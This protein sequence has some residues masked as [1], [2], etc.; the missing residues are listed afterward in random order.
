MTP[1]VPLTLPPTISGAKGVPGPKYSIVLGALPD[2]LTL[3]SS[4]GVISGTPT[5]ASLPGLALVEVVDAFDH[6][7][8]ALVTLQALPPVANND[9]YA[10]PQDTLLDVAAP[11][12]LINH[13]DPRGNGLS[14]SM[15]T[16]PTSGN[17]TLNSDGSFSYTPTAGY[18]GSDSFT[19]KVNDGALDSAVAT[20]QL[21]V[22]E[23]NSPPVANNDAYALPQGT[24]LNVAAPGILANDSDP[25]GHQLSVSIL[26][27]PTNGHLVPAAGGSFSYNPNPG[28][29]GT[30]SFTY[31]VSDGE[32]DSGPAT[33]TIQ[34]NGTA[35]A[36]PTLDR[37]M[38]LLLALMLLGAGLWRF[39]KWA[40]Q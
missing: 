6:R 24:V 10:I 2:G 34:V 36:V 38:I 7:A 3:D 21:T 37:L 33:V 20:V 23:V 12:V 27:Q 25:E 22:N 18:F 14:A 4:T 30:D 17:L 19:Y 40:K 16:Q 26:T 35:Q 32:K 39:S 5:K 29:T 9:T 28:F 31:L 13:T 11:G 8:Q 1:Q 15:V